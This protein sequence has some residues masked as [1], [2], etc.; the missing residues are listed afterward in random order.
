GGGG[1]GRGGGGVGRVRSQGGA[2]AGSGRNGAR[3]SAAAVSSSGNAP[4]KVLLADDQVLVRSGFKVLLDAEDDITVVGEAANG[5]EAVERARATRPGVVL[6]D[7][8][9]PEL[10]RIKAHTEIARTRGLEQGRVLVS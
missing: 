6:M 7:I 5:A 3:V 2:A 9:L 4:I 10:D 8:R 1:G